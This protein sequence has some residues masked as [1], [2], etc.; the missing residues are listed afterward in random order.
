MK[1]NKN[2]MKKKNDIKD[3]IKIK[4]KNGKQKNMK[5]KPNGN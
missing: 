5:K 2:E 4:F 1:H 3:D